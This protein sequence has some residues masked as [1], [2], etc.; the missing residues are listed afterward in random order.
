M[1]IRRKKYYMGRYR[2][3]EKGNTVNMYMGETM[4]GYDC[5]FY[6]FRYNK[7]LCSDFHWEKVGY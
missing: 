6:Y 5:M 4:Q 2:N 3:K 7:V 1:R